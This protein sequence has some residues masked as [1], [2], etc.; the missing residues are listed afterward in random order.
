[1]DY[2][3]GYVYVA[4]GYAGFQV[5]D[6]R[7]PAAPFL[8]S[9]CGTPGDAEGITVV[10]DLAYVGG[11]ESGLR[12]MDVSDPYAAFERGHCSLN[13]GDAEGVDYADGYV[14]VAD[15][16]EGLQIVNVFDP[17]SPEVVGTFKPAY[18]HDFR[19]V[20]V[21]GDFAYVVNYYSPNFLIIDV[22]NPE[23]PS[24]S[25][26]CDT[27][28]TGNH[29]C[30]VEVFGGYAYVADYRGLVVVD[31]SNPESPSVVTTLPPSNQAIRI[32]LCDNWAYVTDRNEAIQLID[33]NDPHMPELIGL[34]P[35]PAP[36]GVAVPCGR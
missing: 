15:G 24:R 32:V 17:D 36:G 5:V 33:V 21:Q 1:M 34:W 4:A 8:A 11:E 31:V 22:S 20:A 2:A 19:D 13:D 23:S 6:V 30:G 7:N 10:G 27:G 3:N 29:A 25:G 16:W 18:Y 14:Y 9:F 28:N 35:T 26:S 12:I